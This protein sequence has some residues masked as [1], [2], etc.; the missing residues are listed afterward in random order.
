MHFLADFALTSGE[1][2]KRSRNSYT[3]CRCGQAGSRAG[4]SSPSSPDVPASSSPPGVGVGAGEERNIFAAAIATT[5]SSTVSVNIFCPPGVLTCSTSSS[6]VTRLSSLPRAS[7]LLPAPETGPP[8][9]SSES[10]SNITE[11][12]AN[13]CLK[14]ASRLA[15]GASASGGN[16]RRAVAP[17]P[18]APP[19]P[20]ASA[21]S[22]TMELRRRS[23]RCACGKAMSARGVGSTPC[24]DA[25]GNVPALPAPLPPPADGPPS[26]LPGTPMGMDVDFCFIRPLSM[27]PG[28][29]R[30]RGARPLCAESTAGEHRACASKATAKVCFSFLFFFFFF[31][32][33]SSKEHKTRATTV[34][35]FGCDQYTLIGLPVV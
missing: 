2:M 20:T 21:A 35:H 11:H 18:R 7:T 25:F 13:F 1:T 31:F 15:G 22:R 16:S 4:S 32:C 24:V 6:R 17:D 28:A 19:P 33:S 26:A 10:Q 30:A 27:A 14:S 29:P 34:G 3:S 5:S 12:S 9:P 8:S 23:R